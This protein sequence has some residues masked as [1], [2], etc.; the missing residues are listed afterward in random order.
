M[1]AQR[2]LRGWINGFSRQSIELRQMQGTCDVVPGEKAH[3][4]VVLL[5]STGS[6]PC[7]E[8]SFK[9][10][11]DDPFAL[12]FYS[13]HRPGGKLGDGTHFDES[14]QK[15]PLPVLVVPL[16]QIR[17]DAFFLRLLFELR[18]LFGAWR[19]LS[20]PSQP[21]LFDEVLYRSSHSPERNALDG[22]VQ[23]SDNNHSLGFALGQ[24]TRHEIENLFLVHLAN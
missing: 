3:R 13:C 1:P 15:E 17:G 16:E 20:S 14:S 11:D 24:A 21:L 8:S 22:G 23:E 4:Q 18:Q 7:V 6:I 10:D 9:V 12:G 19:D 5:V 2:P